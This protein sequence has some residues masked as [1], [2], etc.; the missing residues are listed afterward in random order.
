ME[1][2]SN[3][4]KF[5]FIFSFHCIIGSSEIFFFYFHGYSVT[6]S[7]GFACFVALNHPYGAL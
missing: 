5:T 3:F 1:G 4:V 2:V 7:V 6:F